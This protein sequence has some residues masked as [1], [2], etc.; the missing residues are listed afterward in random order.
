MLAER[1][2]LLVA[3]KAQNAQL[4]NLQ[5]TRTANPAVDIFTFFNMRILC[6]F[7]TPE[8]V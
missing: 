1:V 2:V 8:V 5:G 4:M 3:S 6:C 7:I